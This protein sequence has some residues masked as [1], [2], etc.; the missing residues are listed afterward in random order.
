VRLQ[1]AWK[2]RF[3]TLHLAVHSTHKVSLPAFFNA[4]WD[5]AVGE[6]YGYPGV[7]CR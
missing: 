4:C 6:C 1:H 7:W 2:L 3:A 5:H